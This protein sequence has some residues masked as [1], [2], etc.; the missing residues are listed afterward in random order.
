MS[1]YKSAAAYAAALLNDR[2]APMDNGEG[3]DSYGWDRNGAPT[4]DLDKVVVYSLL[5]AMRAA[6]NIVLLDKQSYDHLFELVQY[7]AIELL[8]KPMS[9][10]TRF[11]A[12]GIFIVIAR[13]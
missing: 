1:K 7:D 12:R 9:E 8:D 6:Q 11:E 5:G 10:L 4:L 3:G 2:M 13:S